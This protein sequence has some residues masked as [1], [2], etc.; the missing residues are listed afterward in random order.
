MLRQVEIY[1]SYLNLNNLILPWISFQIRQV[2]VSQLVGVCTDCDAPIFLLL[3]HSREPRKGQ[4]SERIKPHRWDAF[5]V[6]HIFFRGGVS[7]L[8][9]TAC[10][11]S[12]QHP[13]KSF[14]L[15]PDI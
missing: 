6:P 7:F 9:L 13:D 11:F 4:K 1:K 5:L 15:A 10:A 2:K 3:F 8:G 14:G 12:L